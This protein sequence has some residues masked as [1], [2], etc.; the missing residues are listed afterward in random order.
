MSD[1]EITAEEVQ[2]FLA[3]RNRCDCDGCDERDQL[4]ALIT[5]WADT[6][7]DDDGPDWM[8][9]SAWLALRKAV[10]R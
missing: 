1:D 8:Y 7:D 10:G 3:E 6:E 4:R 9:H 5:A 2:E